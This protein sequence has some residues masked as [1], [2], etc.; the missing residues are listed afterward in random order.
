MPALL[1]FEHTLL[2]HVRQDGLV[3]PEDRVAVAVSGGPD[4][5]ALLHVLSAWRGPLK[6]EL[7][8]VHVDHGLR[9]RESA[10]DA[11]F[12]ER[13]AR[14]LDVP[15]CLKRLNLQRL[16]RERKGESRQ[17]VARE[18]RYELLWEASQEWGGTKV[19]LGH[20]QD[21]QAETVL[22]GMLR[23]AGLAGLSG[24]PAQRPPCVI[25]PFLHVS[26]AEI[27]QYLN[28]KPCGFRVDSSNASPKYLRNRI[29]RELIP[30]LRTFNPKVVR[31]LSRQAAVFRQEHQLLDDAAKAALESVRID[32]A[33]DGVTL[34]RSQFLTHPLPIQRRMI[35][36]TVEKLP[37]KP[38]PLKREAVETILQRVVQGTSGAAARF[39][40]LKVERDY[41]RIIFSGGSVN[42]ERTLNQEERCQWSFPG[43]IRW[44][45]TGQTLEGTIQD[46]D[47]ISIRP[48]AT[49]AYLDADQ[50]SH[51]LVVRSW[52]RGDDFFPYGMAG[53]R[54]KIQDFFSDLKVRRSERNTVPILAAAEGI[55]WV[56][57]YRSDHRF[58]VT[59]KTRR[60]A[61]I[62]LCQK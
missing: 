18:K 33:P 3:S 22:M 4:S 53:K 1:A 29:R 10:D 39:R 21:D 58:R 19:A 42:G 31:V 55:I 27:V 26:R 37:H 5:V 12:V 40:N 50:F 16:L 47:G 59:G 51:E 23:G 41:D 8:V 57:G 48:D 25:R 9:G 60:V 52:K 54:K 62:R 7:I 28:R 43:S 30:L 24:M 13:L 38:G 2:K 6:L 61:V 11:A 17:A 36:L 49:V 45:L 34:S 44:P 46:A 15:F 56:G 14:Q 32:D 20:T 35:F